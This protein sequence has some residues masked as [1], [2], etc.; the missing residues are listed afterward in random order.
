[1]PP[2]T[3]A[4]AAAVL[5]RTLKARRRR[6]QTPG[7][8]TETEHGNSRRAGSGFDQSSDLFGGF[9]RATTIRALPQNAKT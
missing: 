9:E 1:M 4:V 5:I 7:P 2:V 6:G 8:I 3:A